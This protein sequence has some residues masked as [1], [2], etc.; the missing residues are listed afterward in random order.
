[1]ALAIL[2]PRAR[3]AH[4]RFLATAMV[5]GAVYVLFM[6]TVDVPMYLSRWRAD[7]RSGRPYLSVV[8]GWRDA[9]SRRIVT[10]RWEDWRPEMPWMSL[11]FS[12]AVWISI[13]LVRA[14]R[15]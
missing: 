3:G 15:A 11:Y 5:I 2:W 9:A 13:G 4:Q 14:P 7:E 8:E 12:A 6:C 1:M 10:R